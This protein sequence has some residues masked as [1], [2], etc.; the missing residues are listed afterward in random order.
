MVE[1]K[2]RKGKILLDAGK[3]RYIRKDDLFLPCILL[4][5][6]DGVKY[7]KVKSV[8]NWYMVKDRLQNIV[9]NYENDKEKATS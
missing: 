7:Y 5:E 6:K 1:E 8:L 9:D 2:A 3:H 4:E